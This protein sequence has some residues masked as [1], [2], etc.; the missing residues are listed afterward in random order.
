[1]RP[2]H[3][4]AGHSNINAR[5]SEERDLDMK[6]IPTV[7]VSLL[8]PGIFRSRSYATSRYAL[9]EIASKS[10]FIQDDARSRDR[11]SIQMIHSNHESLESLARIEHHHQ[12]MMC[13]VMPL[14]MDILAVVAFCA[15]H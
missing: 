8:L 6:A 9:Y 4:S 3:V 1:M 12:P 10:S 14:L 5:A 13:F 11:N 15:H 7:R 2:S